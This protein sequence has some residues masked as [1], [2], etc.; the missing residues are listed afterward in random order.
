[1]QLDNLQIFDTATAV[2]NTS[3][4]SAFI[5]DLAVARDLGAGERINGI[6]FANQ[7]FAG[8]GS[9]ATINIQ[10]QVST[11]SAGTYST[12]LESGTL[13]SASLG[14]T[15]ATAR[16]WS[17]TLEKNNQNLQGQR[18]M[19]LNYVHPGSGTAFTSGT[20]YSFL[21]DGCDNYTS[22]PSGFT[23]TN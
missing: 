8:V 18:Y 5:L 20:F 23:V 3:V 11:A 12:I 6:I 4:A 16:V 1:M 7:A 21:L 2:T 10:V 17:F 22:Y 15:T 14:Q 9:T 13:T 19:R